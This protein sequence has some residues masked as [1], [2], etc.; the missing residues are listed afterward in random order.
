MIRIDS[1]S[2]RFGIRWGL[3]FG[4]RWGRPGVGA[5]DSKTCEPYRGESG[6][7]VVGV[8]R[9]PSQRS[10]RAPRLAIHF[11]VKL[12]RQ[13]S[14]ALLAALVCGGSCTQTGQAVRPR[15][16][17]A[18]GDRAERRAGRPREA[19]RRRR[20]CACR[21]WRRRPTPS[22]TM[23][24]KRRRASDSPPRSLGRSFC[25]VPIPRAP[26]R[27]ASCAAS[28]GKTRGPARWSR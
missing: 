13:A 15:S 8:A 21:A 12:A 19:R 18:R 7:R 20:L 6:R 27:P 4:V 25:C 1:I 16:H 22:P 5:A 9:F 2:V 14:I 26:F 28:C 11:P 3:R 24:R 17:A 23:P 10:T